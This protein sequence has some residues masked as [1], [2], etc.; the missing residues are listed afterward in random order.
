MGRF[1][2]RVEKNHPNHFG[3]NK[4]GV[5]VKS[6][7]YCQGIWD[8]EFDEITKAIQNTSVLP[9]TPPILGVKSQVRSC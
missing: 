7:R 6:C 4:V 9:P 2:P 3:Q 8:D 1:A 5:P